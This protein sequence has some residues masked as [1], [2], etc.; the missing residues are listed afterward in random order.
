M[1]YTVLAILL[2]GACAGPTTVHSSQSTIAAYQAVRTGEQPTAHGGDVAFCA[3]PST[4]VAQR[5]KARASDQ[6]SDNIRDHAIGDNV[7]GL[8]RTDSGLAG[9]DVS[10]KHGAVKLDGNVPSAAEATRAIARTLEVEGVV[11]VQ[12][13]LFSPDAPNPPPTGTAHWCG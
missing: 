5:V 4:I 3:G 8:L 11:L 1:R 10:V 2:V 9:V 13:R 12:A 7:R 6:W